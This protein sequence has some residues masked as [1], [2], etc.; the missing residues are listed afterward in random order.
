MADRKPR[1]TRE[2]ALNA[3]IAK[4]EEAKAKLKEKLEELNAVG[5]NLKQQLKELADVRKK[6]ERAAEAKAKREEDKKAKK[7]LMKAIKDSGLS[8]NEVKDK[9]GIS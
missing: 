5:E 2:E 6:A 7:E 8:I 4:N 3:K 1:A 9:L